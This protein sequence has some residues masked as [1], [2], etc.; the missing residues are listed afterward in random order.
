MIRSDG[1]HILLIEMKKEFSICLFISNI[2][3]N[4]IINDVRNIYHFP[5]RKNLFSHDIYLI[6]IPE[7]IIII[8]ISL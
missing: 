1:R 5:G 4:D 6:S 2:D 7:D 3:G 8:I